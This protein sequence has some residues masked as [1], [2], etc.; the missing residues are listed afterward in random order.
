[1]ET[2]KGRKGLRDRNNTKLEKVRFLSAA[3]S[4]VLL[5]LGKVFLF[6]SFSHR[7]SHGSRRAV[8]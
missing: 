8:N 3:R 4:S 5:M 7:K 2:E 1:M 6:F